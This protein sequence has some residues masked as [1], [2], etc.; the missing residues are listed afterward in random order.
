MVG[1]IPSKILL[2]CEAFL[3]D[4]KRAQAFSRHLLAF[5]HNV[6]FLVFGDLVFHNHVGSFE[7]EIN[8]LRRIVAHQDPHSFGFG[9]KRE[10]GCI[11]KVPRMENYSC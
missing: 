3:R 11:Q 2:L 7:V 4:N 9:S 6:A 8:F 1:F 5:I 10:V